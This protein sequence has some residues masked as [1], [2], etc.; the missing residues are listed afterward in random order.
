MSDAAEEINLQK[1]TSFQS[2]D[3]FDEPKG[4]P[5]SMEPVFSTAAGVRIDVK[6]ESIDRSA[7]LLNDQKDLKSSVSFSLKNK[8]NSTAFV[9]P[10]RRDGGPSTSSATKRSASEEAD[11]KN[12]E[13]AKKLRRSEEKEKEEKRRERK[14]IHADVLR[15]SRVHEK[16][17]FRLIL[18]DDKTAPLILATISYRRGSD[19]KFGDRLIAEVEVLRKDEAD[20]PTEVYVEKV[21]KNRKNG[22]SSEIRRHSIAK[23]PF[24]LEPRFLYELQNESIKKAVLQIHILDLKMEIYDG[25]TQC[26]HKWE[27]DSSSTR[28]SCPSCK[29]SRASVKKMVFC[30]M[31]VSD[32]SGQHF[33]N[34]STKTMEKFLGLLGYKG[35]EEWHHFI[36]PNERQNYV[37]RPMM[38]EIEKTRH[39]WE[40][41]D[42]AEVVWEDY[43]AYLKEKKS[44][45]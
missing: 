15:V 8:P 40:C 26:L 1:Q 6:Q 33:I 16:D 24:C 19:I 14:E 9:S 13:P 45:F 25:C 29:S 22:A 3:S 10:F 20:H 32:F 4:V 39:E 5:I 43:G 11:A 41:T 2:T 34:I 36:E 21:V 35:V 23:M 44:K 7:K 30:R 37:F 28:K 42:V 27:K 18:Q 38:I 12:E 31:R 17:Q